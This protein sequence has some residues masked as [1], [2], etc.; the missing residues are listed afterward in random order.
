MSRLC[1][2]DIENLTPEKYSSFASRAL[3]AWFDP[4]A[5]VGFRKVLEYEDLW[6]L[7]RANRCA[8]VVPMWDAQWNRMMENRSV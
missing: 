7:V 2:G 6:G 5:W 8:G 1:S 3:F 4:F